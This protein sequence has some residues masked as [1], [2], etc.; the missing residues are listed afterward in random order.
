MRS[1][2]WAPTIALSWFWGLGFFYSVHLTVTEGWAG[3]LAFAIPN[4]VGLAAFGIGL[5]RWGPSDLA[6]A[7][8]RLAAQHVLVV[9]SYQ[10]LA[11]GLTWFVFLDA[12][13]SPLF[14]P[15]AV[16]VLLAA[17]FLAL[18]LGQVLGISGLK[19]L[20]LVLLPGAVVAALV[21]V[22]TLPTVSGAGEV[23]PR[24]DLLVP[25][26]V[27]F[28]LGPW[29]DVQQWQRAAAI[30]RNGG[31]PAFG[32]SAAG[33][34]FFVLLALNAALVAGLPSAA[35]LTVNFAGAGD[36]THALIARLALAEPAALV[37]TVAVVVWAAI[38]FITT[39]DSAW[40][41]I[42]WTMGAV[43]ARSQSPVAAFIPAGLALTPVWTFAVAGLVA[44]FAVLSDLSLLD[45]MAPYATLFA[46][47]SLGIVMQTTRGA[48]PFDGTV[49]IL[50]GA[51]SL[52][53]FG[54][55]YYADLALLTTIAPLLPFAAVL[56][57]DRVPTAAPAAPTRSVTAAPMEPVVRSTDTDLV[58]ARGHFDGEWFNLAVT[59]TYDDTNSVGNVYFTNYIRWVGRAREMFFA[60]C[61]PTFDVRTTEFLI[62]TRDVFHQFVS[63]IREFE[64]AVVRLRVGKV[65]RKFV[66]L[67]HEIRT[68]DGRLVGKGNQ[69]LMFVDSRQYRLIDIP[70]EVIVGF[71][72]F[73]GRTREQLVTGTAFEQRA[74]GMAVE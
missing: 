24:L 14:G 40:T 70:R 64:S 36:A 58:P 31:S 53:A 38:A 68:D 19:R 18:A 23:A 42:R 44:A 32:Y 50:L 51:L 13:A 25:T 6:D 61:L 48:L 15:Y 65:N 16:P 45:L 66:S 35:A 59:P 1:V 69:Q 5:Q 4:A 63:E 54:I 33:L 21:A 67:E 7:L 11:I 72:P 2:L 43:R 22:A 57:A 74:A 62:L 8:E 73:A 17:T 26:L 55:G 41:A 30:A 49:T 52:T 20:H 27:G 56:T 29:L 9:L 37:P 60:N 34:L 28:L 47:F 46:G 12:F 10:A 39:L 71:M 3:F